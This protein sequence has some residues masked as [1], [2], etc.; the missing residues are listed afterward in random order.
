M[1]NEEILKGIKFPDIPEMIFTCKISNKRIKQID[2]A[3]EDYCD[4]SDLLE[5][6][7]MLAQTAT[8]LR[9]ELRVYS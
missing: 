1:R 8:K 7:K 9:K 3:C 6:R 5:I 4:N 2:P